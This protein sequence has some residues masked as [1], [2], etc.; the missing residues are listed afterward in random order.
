[1]YV[2][3]VLRDCVSSYSGGLCFGYWVFN[4]FVELDYLNCLDDLYGYWRG[5]IC[6]YYLSILVC[7]FSF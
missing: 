2:G 3:V 7:F 5:V 1:M 6:F 4:I